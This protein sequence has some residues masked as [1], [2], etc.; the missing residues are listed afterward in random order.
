MRVITAPNSTPAPEPKRDL[1]SLQDELA[2]LVRKSLV[3]R[4]AMES[5]GERIRELAAQIS[6]R[7]LPPALDAK[8]SGRKE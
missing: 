2:E 8:N 6:S 4:A 3:Q 7:L 5:T 1:K